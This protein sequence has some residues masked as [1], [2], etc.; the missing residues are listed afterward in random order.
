MHHCVV[1]K[2]PVESKKGTHTNTN[3]KRENKKIEI[4]KKTIG[5]E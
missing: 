3:K 1:A 5:K 2:Q 4:G